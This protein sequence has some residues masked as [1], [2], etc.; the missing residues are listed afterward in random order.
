MRSHARLSISAVDISDVAMEIARSAR[1]RE[2][3]RK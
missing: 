2:N 3:A 1:I